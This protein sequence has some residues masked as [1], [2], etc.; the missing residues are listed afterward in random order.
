MTFHSGQRVTLKRVCKWRKTEPDRPY[1]YHGPFP[2]FG[3]VYVVSRIE[4]P[5]GLGCFLV[6]RE[7]SDRALFLADHFRPVVDRPTDISIFTR[8]LEPRTRVVLSPQEFDAELR[9]R[10][11]KEGML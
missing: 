11:V 9:R 4:N 1:Y 2:E 10:L 7:F 6:L 8:M 3:V 5:P